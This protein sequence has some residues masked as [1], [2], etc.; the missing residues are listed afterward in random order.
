MRLNEDVITRLRNNKRAKAR[1][2]YELDICPA[3]LYRII[4]ANDNN[5]DFTKMG[6]VKVIAEELGVAEESILTE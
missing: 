4:N 2:L 3:T 6:A 5:N 1:V